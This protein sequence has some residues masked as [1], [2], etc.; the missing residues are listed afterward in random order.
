MEEKSYVKQVLDDLKA[1]MEKKSPG[2][3]SHPPKP[4]LNM[5]DVN[6]QK[7]LAV[8]ADGL[9][10]LSKADRAWFGAELAKVA[11]GCT[12]LLQH[13]V[14]LSEEDLMDVRKLRRIIWVDSIIFGVGGHDSALKWPEVRELLARHVDLF[15]PQAVSL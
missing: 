3:F 10:Q 15:Q 1:R 4:P 7:L 14:G 9:D 2:I 6:V 8:K 5:P 13:G 12:E 11:D